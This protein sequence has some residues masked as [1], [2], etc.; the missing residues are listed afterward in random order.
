MSSPLEC[1]ECVSSTCGTSVIFEWHDPKLTDEVSE[2]SGLMF[3]SKRSPHSE[4][5]SKGGISSYSEPHSDET[6]GLESSIIGFGYCNNRLLNNVK[7]SVSNDDGEFLDG[8]IF[9]KVCAASSCN[10]QTNKG[11]VGAC[12]NC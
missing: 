10:L 2:E 8:S 11:S 12:H 1:C 9:S 6:I 5:H 4:P 7:G 3:K